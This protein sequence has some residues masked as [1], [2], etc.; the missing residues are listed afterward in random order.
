MPHYAVKVP[1]EGHKVPHEALRVPYEAVKVSHETHKVPHDAQKVSC[2][3]VNVV[4]YSAKAT[5][6][7]TS[8]LS[9]APYECH[10][11]HQY[12]D[13]RARDSAWR[14]HSFDTR[15]A[16]VDI[17]AAAQPGEMVGL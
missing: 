2:E 1:H 3:T 9:E 10:E 12:I 16:G 8:A 17:A 6:H 11:R 14:D 5:D 13:L 7:P 15:G 4:Y